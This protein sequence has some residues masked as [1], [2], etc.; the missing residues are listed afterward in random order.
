[1]TPEQRDRIDAQ[2][3]KRV[4][5]AKQ[6]YKEAADY[7]R[8]AKLADTTAVRNNLISLGAG[9]ETAGRMELVWAARERLE[10]EDA[11]KREVAR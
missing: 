1:M 5:F 4:E 8:L 2:H 10:A 3:A 11:A 7:Y 9:K 6:M